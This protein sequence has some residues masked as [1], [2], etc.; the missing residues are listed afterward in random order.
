MPHV[1]KRL[2]GAGLGVGVLLGMVGLVSIAIAQTPS[3]APATSTKFS[4]NDRVRVTEAVKVRS[5][6]NGSNQGTQPAGS[7]GTITGGPTS[8]GG[9]WW[10]QINYDSAPDGWSVENYLEKYV[11][12]TPSASP[13][14]TPTP[15][16]VP[17]T[18][19]SPS[20]SP[21]TDATALTDDTPYKDSMNASVRQAGWKYYYIDIPANMTGNVFQVLNLSADVDLYVRFGAL[22]AA[23]NWDCRSLR[24]GKANE[25]CSDSNPAAGRWYIGVNNFETG[26]IEYSVKATIGTVAAPSP[27]ASPTSVP[28]PT[29]SVVPTASPSPSPSPVPAPLY[30][31]AWSSTIGWLSFNSSNTGSGGGPHSVILQP[32]GSLVGYAWSSNIGWVK[33][34]GLSSFPTNGTGSNSNA[35][36][37]DVEASGDVIGWARA[38]A[39]TVTGDCSTMASRADGW[40]GWIELTGTN[41]KTI[42]TYPPTGTSTIT[43]YAWGGDVVGWLEFNVTTS[44]V[45]PNPPPP[46]CTTSCGGEIV[47]PTTP[48]SSCYA[49]GSVYVTFK[50][51]PPAGGVPSGSVYK[52]NVND[53][54]PTTISPD[55]L[56]KVTWNA[57]GT[58]T[59]RAWYET[60]G[61]KS[62]IGMLA[63]I[64]MGECPAEGET[65][66]ELSVD[67]LARYSKITNTS[68]NK[69]AQGNPIVKKAKVRKNSIFRLAGVADTRKF[70]PDS[71]RIRSD[72]RSPDPAF[73]PTRVNGSQDIRQ[74]TALVNYT[75]EGETLRSK[76][77]VQTIIQVQAIDPLI[78][79][80]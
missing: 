64:S 30:G 54:D 24:G 55:T 53:G 66:L 26:N 39:G 43:G 10:W 3:P 20:P 45:Q 14:P 71:V 34:G 60:N 52:Y 70:E 25:S 15:T 67:P 23:T 21:S 77:K 13:T 47:P 32:D 73:D 78:E 31:W 51:M 18:S 9:Y 59:I 49:N 19:G 76:L 7:L 12:A 41:H 79:E 36:V 29:P 75:L 17:S 62:A 48:G 2:V 63:P 5:T 27:S 50:V 68:E 56:I 46:I 80:I 58:K 38:C 74:N 28:T 33:F 4:I 65:K 69:D 57:P 61:V 72:D 16:A 37:L 35:R 40:D 6:P 8:A 1:Y 11:A 22:P 44:A 42:Y